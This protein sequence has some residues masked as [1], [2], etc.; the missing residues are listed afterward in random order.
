MDIRDEY[1]KEACLY[2][3]KD[4]GNKPNS[5]LLLTMPTGSGKTYTAVKA[6]Y[7]LYQ[8]EQ[9]AHHK[10]VLWVAHRDFLLEDAER[11]FESIASIYNKQQEWH[12]EKIIFITVDSLK[13]FT[14]FESLD[15]IVIDEAHHSAARSY[16]CLFDMNIKVLGLTATPFRSDE[17]DLN[18]DGETYAIGYDQLIDCG[19]IIDPVITSIKT[20]DQSEIIDPEKLLKG[21]HPL[22]T[23]D[24]NR[25]IFDHIEEHKD[26][27]DKVVIFALNIKHI[28]NLAYFFEKKTTLHAFGYEIFWISGKENNLKESRTEFVKRCRSSVK[29]IIINYNV[30]T[31]GYDDPTLNCAIMARPTSSRL[32]YTQAVGRVLRKNINDPGKKAYVVEICDNMPNVR[33]LIDN[34]ILFAQ[35]SDKLEPVITE[36]S[37]SSENDLKNK[38]EKFVKEKE[39]IRLS[40]ANNIDELQTQL[41]DEGKLS[42]ICFTVYKPGEANN[43]II[44]EAN[45]DNIRLYNYL[46]RHGGQLCKRTISL[47]ALQ[48]KAAEYFNLDQPLFKLSENDSMRVRECLK[49][50]AEQLDIKDRSEVVSVIEYITFRKKIVFYNV[51]DEFLFDCVNSELIISQLGEANSSK[52]FLVKLPLSNSKFYAYMVSANAYAELKDFYES[53]AIYMKSSNVDSDEEFYKACTKFQSFICHSKHWSALFRLLCLDEGLENYILEI[54]NAE[55]N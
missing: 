54:P 37:E 23:D 16:Q 53:K 38:F 19:A 40:T 21:T 26:E 36:Y 32:F 48:S 9:I 12:R 50:A 24:R 10:K 43:H 17:I 33:Y 14:D 39:P 46:D 29:C 41:I 52:K 55:V 3:K 22:D 18:F 27:Y 47:D 6:V 20:N 2:I 13:K 35:I 7:E 34:R 11:S 45:S 4:F 8:H 1:Q 15:L 31:E 42:L 25:L 49:H 5:R 30:L 28:K 51:I 44:I